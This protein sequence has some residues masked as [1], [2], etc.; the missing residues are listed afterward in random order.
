MKK[1]IF[2]DLDGT[3]TDS[4]EGIMNSLKYALKKLGIN[5][6][7][8]SVLRTFV[9]PPIKEHAQEI[10]GV[11]KE[12]SDK[13]LTYYRE[14]FVLKGM[15]ENSVYNGVEEVLKNLKKASK[16]LAVATSKPEVHAKEILRHFGLLDYFGYVVGATLDGKISEK[17]DVIKTALF[18]AKIDGKNAVMVGDRKYDINGG[19]VFNMLTVGVTYGY[20]SEEELINANADYVA[21]SA[22]EL[23]KILMEI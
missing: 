3:L 19:K 5:C 4:G 16:I 13:L 1:I 9:G 11:T 21:K 10:F 8:E 15:Y 7:D 2:F 14:Y 12:D 6:N 22:N 23:E 20:G 17:I 18:R